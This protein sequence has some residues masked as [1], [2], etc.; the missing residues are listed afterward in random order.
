MRFSRRDGSEVPKF[1]Y[2]DMEEYRDMRLTAEAF[3]C[4]LDRP[5]LE[6]VSAGIALQAYLPGAFSVQKEI[7]ASA[8][9]RVRG[10]AARLRSDWL[11]ERPWNWSRWERRSRAGRKRHSRPS[12][13]WMPTINA[14]CTRGC[15]GRALPE[16][17]HVGQCRWC[18]SGGRRLIRTN[19]P[20]VAPERAV[21]GRVLRR[22]LWCRGGREQWC[23]DATLRDLTMESS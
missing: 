8:R 15:A 2:L 7:D 21:T 16:R 9:V 1:V 13:R 11:T 23:R 10:V 18:G 5:G 14:C 3:M 12:R 20:A 17:A 4:T 22:R 19:P 6:G